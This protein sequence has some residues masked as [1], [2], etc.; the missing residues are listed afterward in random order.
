VTVDITH[1]MQRL[2]RGWRPT[3]SVSC[4]VGELSAFVAQYIEM[5]TKLDAVEAWALSN[6]EGDGLRK[7]LWPPRGSVAPKDGE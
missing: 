2:V 1:R 6:V 4:N 5:R 7:V 3:M